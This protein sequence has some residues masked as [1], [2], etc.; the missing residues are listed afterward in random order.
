MDSVFQ[1]SSPQAHWLGQPDHRPF[2]DPRMASH[3]LVSVTILD[4]TT[5]DYNAKWIGWLVSFSTKLQAWRREMHSSP[6]DGDLAFTRRTLYSQA[7]LFP[8]PSG[9]LR[10]V[11]WVQPQT[12]RA[13]FLA[14]SPTRTAQL[15]AACSRCNSLTVLKALC[16]VPLS[17]QLGWTN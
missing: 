2:C 14:F 17:A 5:G 16:L 7:I 4:D 13:S 1:L 9:F 10:L 6:S 8:L 15:I 12:A 3:W 11:W